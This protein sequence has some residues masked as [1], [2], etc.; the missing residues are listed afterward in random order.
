ML[1][2]TIADD[3]T[4]ENNLLLYLEITQSLANYDTIR[5][6]LGGLQTF[7]EIGLVSDCQTTLGKPKESV[8]KWTVINV[9]NWSV[10]M[11]QS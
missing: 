5:D 11:D 10:L 9:P 7:P 1:A 8:P 6:K 4:Q 3:I 2:R